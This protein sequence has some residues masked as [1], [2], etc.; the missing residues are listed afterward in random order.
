[1]CFCVSETKTV[2][3]GK[4]VASPFKHRS[5]TE[6]ALVARISK[7]ILCHLMGLKTIQTRLHVRPVPATDHLLDLDHVVSLQTR[8]AKIVSSMLLVLGSS[9]FYLVTHDVSKTAQKQRICLPVSLR[10]QVPAMEVMLCP[11]QSTH[12]RQDAVR[13]E[14]VEKSN[15]SSTNGT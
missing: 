6:C 12:I 8:K 7:S 2:S 11:I 9:K 5:R 15:S 1:M 13:F 10:R 3:T 4:H 14:T